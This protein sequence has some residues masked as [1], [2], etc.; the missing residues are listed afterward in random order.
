M[1]TP[2]DAVSCRSKE[3]MKFLRRAIICAFAWM[4]FSAMGADIYWDTDAAAPLVG[5]SST[6]NL[7]G[8]YFSSSPSGDTPL[9][10]NSSGDKW[11]FQ[12][13]TVQAYT[14]TVDIAQTINSITVS[15][16]NHVT[17]TTASL[18]LTCTNLISIQG[19]SSLTFRHTANNIRVLAD[20][21][22]TGGTP[23]VVLGA[24][25]NTLTISSGSSSAYWLKSLTGDA[26]D[27]FGATNNTMWVT[28]PGPST[29]PGQLFGPL[30]LS[31]TLTLTAD[32]DDFTGTLESSAVTL[33]DGGTS[34]TIGSAS[35]TAGGTLRINR[36][37]DYVFTNAIASWASNKSFNLA[38]DGSGYVTLLGDL[39]GDGLLYFRGGSGTVRGDVK[40][41]VLLWV[42]EPGTWTLAGTNIY[43]GGATT[44][45]PLVRLKKAGANL[46]I[47]DGSCY[48]M[49]TF[50]NNFSM[51]SGSALIMDIT[52]G[53]QLTV[54]SNLVA[55]TGC[56]LIIIGEG[57]ED[58]VISYS[59]ALTPF[60]NVVYNGATSTWAAA[61]QPKG[62]GGKTQ[63]RVE[64]NA[65]YIDPLPP[66]G[67]VIIFE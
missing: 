47:G 23:A 12:T 24:G 17:M 4:A 15:N 52:A 1:F 32:N 54:I 3:K 35:M 38:N 44:Y 22:N 59:N 21:R 6:L 34:G 42:E 51:V 43:A 20:S 66:A 33:G 14:T 27:R 10:A 2:F 64:S 36:S 30:R 13:D 39:R 50:S 8:T 16:G 67:T 5:S 49:A 60:E 11:F 58:P 31:A 46:Q 55:G 9:T 65:I 28:I 63:M 45:N 37:D 26:D 7:S 18:A 61:Q 40:A 25:A 57:Q 56:N 62:L 53:A 41:G 48:S 29:F 19:G